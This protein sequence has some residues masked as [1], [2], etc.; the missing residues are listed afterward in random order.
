MISVERDRRGPWLFTLFIFL[1]FAYALGLFSGPIVPDDLQ[2]KNCARNIHL[3]YG[4][5][6]SLNCDSGVHLRAAHDPTLLFEQKR[7]VKGRLITPSAMEQTTP[8]TSYVV[9]LLAR[10]FHMVWQALGFD[11]VFGV[12]TI[13]ESLDKGYE[14]EGIDQKF[15]DSFPDIKTLIPTYAGFILY[16]VL[17]LFLAYGLYASSVRLSAIK[18]THYLYPAMWIGAVVLINDVTKQYLFS[19]NT[20]MFNVMVPFF[21]VWWGIKVLEAKDP[22]KAFVLGA[23]LCGIGMLFYHVFIISV[24]TLGLM[25]LINVWAKEKVLSAKLLTIPVA[26][27]AFIL[28][29]L[30]WYGYILVTQGSFYAY[31]VETNP[32]FTIGGVFSNEGLWA[33][34]SLYL[35]NLAQVI[36]RIVTHGWMV[37][38]L[39][40]L[41]L[42]FVKR[43]EHFTALEKRLLMVAIPYSI[44]LPLFFV[45]YGLLEYRVYLGAALVYLPFVGALS[46]RQGKK[47]SSDR[48][49]LIAVIIALIAYA[50]FVVSKFSPYG[51]PIPFELYKDLRP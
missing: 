21:T 15:T 47:P 24:C 2:T 1:F 36:F 16:H 27:F 49:L 38:A 12:D 29:Y 50:I 10:P 11:S 13:E 3:S 40:G 20:Q 45:A 22:R 8:G 6:T 25:F 18:P 9:W 33:G 37:F 35:Q 46:L 19:P 48:Y 28:P 51:W 4:L 31:D 43:L 44:M 5:G 26:I 34:V 41:V 32:G 23:F 39:C 17:T 42:I 14:L 7:E 30:P